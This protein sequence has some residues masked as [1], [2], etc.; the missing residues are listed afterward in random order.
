MKTN[1]PIA[2]VL[3]FSCILVAILSL[4]G[5]A[6]AASS[7]DVI[8]VQNG[9]TKP[10]SIGSA[11]VGAAKPS[12]TFTVKNLG[13]SNLTLGSVTIPP[14]FILSQLPASVVGPGKQTT[15]V[16][17]L[18][19][20]K[21]GTPS[22]TVSIVNNDPKKN[23]FRFA[24]N[25]TVTAR[26]AVPDIDVLGVA[27]HQTA[28]VN[29]GKVSLGGAPP[30]STFVVRNTGT[31]ALN[32]SR[33]TVPSGFVVVRAPASSVLAGQQTSFI[34]GLT[35]AREGVFSGK[36]AITSNDPDES[37]YDFTVMGTVERIQG[38]PEISVFINGRSYATSSVET[39]KTYVYRGQNASDP[40]IVTLRNEGREDLII[41]AW[42]LSR[43]F[44]STSP[45][46][47]RLAPGASFELRIL[48]STSM[49]DF[50]DGLL[51][52]NT[53]D[54]DEPRFTI[55][56]AGIVFEPV[57]RNA[58]EKAISTFPD[59][60]VTIYA[61][62]RWRYSI[63]PENGGMAWD[64]GYVIRGYD[65]NGRL[66]TRLIYDRR[67]TKVVIYPNGPVTVHNWTN[68]LVEVR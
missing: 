48:P 17:A 28:P 19:T 35:T 54:A 44:F 37:P 51:T 5:A 30:S 24:I 53:N 26:S 3:R 18:D 14:G 32:I 29:L 50:R 55:G 13:N 62:T 40:V 43:G 45:V 8:G 16:I 56:L 41:S 7:I 27:N 10:L 33:I 49:P 39:F 59:G 6:Q 12:C 38:A 11:M 57:Q 34:V 23:P 2:V 60:Q 22:G 21:V 52:F 20:A 68:L 66:M 1:S 4:V 67:M 64:G 42:N 47:G 25:G 31:K 58:L 15:F 9:Q 46:P 36:V 61:S 65:P 63:E